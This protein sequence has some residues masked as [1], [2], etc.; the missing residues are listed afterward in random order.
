[1]SNLN[2]RGEKLNLNLGMCNNRGDLPT[3]PIDGLNLDPNPIH[4]T[5]FGIK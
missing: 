4:L 5:R 2:Y 3:R 1:M